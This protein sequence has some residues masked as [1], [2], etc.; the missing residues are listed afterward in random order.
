MTTAATASTTGVDPALTPGYDAVLLAGFGGPEGP[1][2]VMPFL[3]NVTRGRGIPDERL[4]EVSHHYL[5]L[6]GSSP[7]NAQNRALRAALEQELHRRGVALPVLW[8]NRNWA[9]YLADEIRAAHD[10]GQIRLLGVA[11]SAYSSYSGCRQYREDFGLALHA[12]DLVG[13]VR[14]DKV[15][16][17]FDRPAFATG[18]AERTVETVRAGLAHGVPP[19][20]LEIVFTTHSIPDPMA[21]SSGSAA[22]GDHDRPGGAYVAQHLAV[23]RV[24]ADT[25][26]AA[27]DFPV[28]WQLAYQS[29]SGPPAMPWLDPDINDVID[30]LAAAG[31]RGIVVVPIG[32]VSDHVEVVWDLDNEAAER[33][34]EAGLWFARV[35]TPGTDPDFVA[36]LADLVE[37]RLSTAPGDVAEADADGG[38]IDARTRPDFC[39]T[40]CCV[41][42]R[43]PKPTTAGADSAQDWAGLDVAPDRL[44]ASGVPGVVAA[45]TAAAGGDDSG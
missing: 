1:D 28:S 20:D 16:P 39:A 12:T 15:Q 2:D 26:S 24:V 41:N 36:M 23:A 25:V 34:A 13:S 19:A 8:G 38:A 31:K 33:A 11:T 44:R 29:R 9:P 22:L 14:I 40:R 6:G 7:I 32:F 43:A 27:I 21:D 10:R 35:A 42:L 18:F 37:L 4:V 3:R 5:A 30:T 45:V 17:Y